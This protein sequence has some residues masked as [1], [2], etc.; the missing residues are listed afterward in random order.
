MSDVKIISKNI[1]IARA[2]YYPTILESKKEVHN[3]LKTTDAINS[4]YELFGIENDDWNEIFIF[5]YYT[6]IEFF[7]QLEKVYMN[8]TSNYCGKHFTQLYSLCQRFSIWGTH[9]P[10]GTW[11][12]FKR[13]AK[14]YW[15]MKEMVKFNVVE[16]VCY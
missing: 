16:I 13:Y 10:K 5:S 1:K 2:S 15:V 7:K 9:T 14:K 11:Y 4:K 12:D 6:I 8:G 3:I